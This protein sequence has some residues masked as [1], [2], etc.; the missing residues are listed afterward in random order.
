MEI[1][2]EL[3]HWFYFK[4]NNYT[5]RA[6]TIRTTGYLA[7]LFVTIPTTPYFAPTYPY[8]PL[9]FGKGT[10]RYIGRGMVTVNI[11]PEVFV[12]H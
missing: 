3:Q 1:Q 12:N 11:V 4:G 7:W 6:T 9:P 5:S 10:P 8:L 2:M